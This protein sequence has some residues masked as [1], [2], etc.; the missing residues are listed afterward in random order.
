[1]A[2]KTA[3]TGSFSVKAYI[4]DFKTLLAF[5]FSD[6]AR[7]QKLAGFSIGCKPPVGQSYYLWNTLQ[8][9]DPSKHAQIATEKPQS[10]ANAPVQKFRWTHVPGSVHQGVDPAQGNYTYTVTP[11]YFDANQS[12]QPLDSSLSASVTVPVGPFTT[13]NLSLGFTRGYMQ[14][15]AFARHFGKGTRIVPVNRPLQ[16]DTASQAGTNNNQAVTYAE[17]YAWMG[18]TA[19][20][21]IFAILDA[22]VADP[23]LSIDVFA[24][25]LDEPDIVGIFLKLAAEGR[26]RMILDN[27]ALHSKPTGK[28][29]PLENPFTD[30]FKQQAKSPAAIV[31]GSFGRFSHDK[32]FIVSKNG[33]PNQVLTGSTNFS[34]TGLYV[35]ANHVLVFNDPNL[36]AE[37]AKVF[38]QSWAILSQTKTPS[39]GAAT[40]FAKTALATSA[41]TPPS[42]P[43]PKLS[44]HYSPHSADDTDKILGAISDRIEQEAGA[45]KGSVLFAVMQ[46]TGSPSEVYTTLSKVHEN[47]KIYSY[48]IS[49]APDGVFLYQPGSTE[50]VQVTGKPGSVTLP[51]PFDQVP[52]PPGHE[53]HDKFVVCGLNGPDPVVY[54]G[55]SNLAT[56]GEKENGDNL[57]EIHDAD[58]ATAFAIES[59]L[60]VDHYNFLDRFGAKKSAAKKPAAQTAGKAASKKSARKTASSSRAA[61]RGAAKKAAPKRKAA[62]KKRAT[63][64]AAPKK[65]TRKKTATKKTAT[66]KTATKKTAA[67]KAA[68]R[69]K[70]SRKR[71][72]ASGTRR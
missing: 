28:K 38:Q 24:Y 2:F 26:I 25:D 9:P 54:C 8:F 49:D 39:Q 11:R 19:R 15:E 68:P 17:I 55:S 53:I 35:N 5:N 61:K 37:Y 16:F 59:L 72:A 65:A 62:T 66:K 29:I 4:G 70:A 40:A 22:V 67:K 30:D 20:R 27:A 10:T 51:T 23:S 36:A 14:S 60:L 57:L 12:M 69:K 1:M 63:K 50:G 71:R 3:S 41:F 44:I 6:P 47:A 21:Q 42:P 45:S 46:L 64:K 32:I 58:V 34:V 56:G 52:T 48:G 18:S 33:S 7:A 43:A 31:R 13:A